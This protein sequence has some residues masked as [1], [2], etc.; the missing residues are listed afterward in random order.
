MLRHEQHDFVSALNSNQSETDSGITSS[1]FDDCAPGPEFSIGLGAKNDADGGAIFYAAARI[2]V[3]QLGIHA[4][5][6]AWGQL[7]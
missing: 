1:G 4:G 3:F 5:A 2:E 7:L 6:T